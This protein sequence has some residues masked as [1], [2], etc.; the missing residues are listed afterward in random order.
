[1]TVVDSR[2]DWAQCLGLDRLTAHAQAHVRVGEHY[3]QHGVQ[4][5]HCDRYTTYAGVCTGE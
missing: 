4:L 2:I 5:R 1:M 3:W